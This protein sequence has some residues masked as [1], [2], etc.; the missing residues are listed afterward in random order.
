[1]HVVSE[2]S[3]LDE[4]REAEGTLGYEKTE[5]LHV[6]TDSPAEGPEIFTPVVAR[7]ELVPVDH[8]PIAGERAHGRGGQKGEIWERGGVN[9]VV[10]SS[11]PHQV[12]E[13]PEAECERR[14]DSSASTGEH[15]HPWRD[16]KDADGAQVGFRS[17][18]PVPHR[19]VRDLVALLCEPKGEIAIPAFGAPHRLRVE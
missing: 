8:D 11:V 6:P 18:V 4:A 10:V 13:Y 1:M 2:Q 12:P 16:R 9:H 15:G 19:E 3:V 5:A 17:R 14:Q 7:P